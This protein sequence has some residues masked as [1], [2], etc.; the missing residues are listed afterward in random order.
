MLKSILVITRARLQIARNT[1]WRGKLSRKIALSL[2]LLVLLGGAFGLYT[3]MRVSVE[4]LSSPSFKRMLER[5]A[6]D[7]P[8]LPTDPLPFLHALPGLA[9]F[10]ALAVL[11]VTGLSSVLSSLY[12]SGDLD[13]LLIAP[14]PIRAV[15]VVKFLEGLVTPYLLLFLLIG[16]ALMGFGMGLGYGPAYYGMLLLILLLF[17]LLPTGLAAILVLVLIRFVPARRAREIVSVIGGLFGAAWYLASQ[18]SRQITENISEAQALN[19]MRRTDNLLLPSAWASRALIAAG[20]GL[21]SQLML[22][23]GLFTLASI[24]IFGLCLILSEKLYY[25][26]WS[27]MASQEGKGRKSRSGQASIDQ[28]DRP[29]AKAWWTGLLSPASA[30]ILAKDMLLFRRDLRNT[31]RLIFPLALAGFWTYQLIQGR[32]IATQGSGMLSQGYSLSSAG[33]AYLV[34]VSL[35][36]ALGGPGIS[37]EGRAFWLLKTAPINAW[38]I[39]LSKG[40]LAYLPFPL[41]GLPMTLLVTTLQQLDLLSILRAAM[42]L[43]LVGFGATSLQLGFGAAFPRL[44]WENPQQQTTTRAG[45]LTSLATISYFAVTLGLVLG[46][47]VLAETFAASFIFVAQI[48]GWL[49]AIVITLLVSWGLLS[50]G[51]RRLEL[52]EL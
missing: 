12:L 4:A 28:A 13:M 16:P 52:L 20:E 45:C 30:A 8:T 31:Q 29:T 51:A 25:V 26:G 40:L 38:Q 2:F 34:C 3:L 33:L 47:P 1:F 19:N 21:W 27:N 22:Y 11:V 48:V 17:P 9:L 41:I 36:Q 43:L 5:A 24:L 14:I 49:A 32:A 15:F 23:G 44:D 42:L 18:F 10:F 39:L 37:R 6:Q 46:L 35:S 50:F 7:M